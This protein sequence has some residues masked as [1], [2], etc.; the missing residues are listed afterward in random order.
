MRQTLS[1]KILD[2]LNRGKNRLS[3]EAI[4]RLTAYI[5]SQLLP[6][7]SFMDKTGRSDLYYTLFGWMLCWVLKIELDT[8][9]MKVYLDHQDEKNT[10]LIHYA[11]LKRCVVVCKLFTKGKSAAAVQVLRKQQIRA[12]D[13]F[14]QVPN[15]DVNAPYTQYIWLSLL[16]DTGNKPQDTKQIIASLASYATGDGGYANDTTA[17]VATTNATVA[18]LAV[19]GQLKG[20]S[21]DPALDYLS[22]LQHRN[23]GFSATPSSAI[24]DVLSTA[25]ALFLLYCYGVK[26]L[27]DAENFIEAHWLEPGGFAATLADDKSDIEYCFYGLLAL[28]CV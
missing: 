7:Q 2:A 15:N 18:A 24:P 28:G 8:V 20:F 11:C 17:T 3:A 22:K 6:D 23:G 4:S 1:E 9:R 25:T 10:D 21:P 26:P 5:E 14:E 19:S 13:Q 27:Y 12:I 16:E